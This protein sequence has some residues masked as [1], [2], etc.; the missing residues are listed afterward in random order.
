M[1]IYSD[2]KH[3]IDKIQDANFHLNMQSL[4]NEARKTDAERTLFSE[5]RRR[6]EDLKDTSEDLKVD[7]MKLAKENAEMREKI[8][9]LE[10]DLKI[11]NEV[12]DQQS[13]RARETEEAT[14]RELEALDAGIQVRLTRYRR[15]SQ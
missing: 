14:K 3:G 6:N 2:L 5:L 12:A 15:D 11:A 8:D 1:D 9:Q 7:R 13:R 10:C 4:A